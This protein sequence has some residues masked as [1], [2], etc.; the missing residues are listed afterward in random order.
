MSHANLSAGQV[1]PGVLRTPE[2]CFANLKMRVG[3]SRKIV[4]WL[5]Q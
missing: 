3:K 4:A 2:E 1:K 5:R